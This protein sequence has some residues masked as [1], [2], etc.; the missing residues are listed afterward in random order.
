MARAFVAVLALAAVACG[1]GPRADPGELVSEE[2]IDIDGTP[3]TRIRYGSIDVNGGRTEVTG[4]V[5]I[6]AGDPPP[7]GWPV[8]A[9]AHSTTGG[10]DDCAPSSDPDVADVGRV[11][12]RLASEGF[13]A[14]A[15]DYEGIGG[16]GDHPYLHGRSEAQAVVDSVRAARALVPA[17]GLVWAVLGHSQGGHAAVFTAELAPELGPE[18]QLV[19]AVAV[20]PVSEPALLAVDSTFLAL[21]TVGYLSTD[22]GV[23]EEELLTDA[24]RDVIEQAREECVVAGVDE[25]LLTRSEP[26]LDAYLH[27]NAV[28][29]QATPVPV[30]IQ[31]GLDDELTPP[32]GARRALARL[33]QLGVAVEL[34]EY[35]GADHAT[36]VE[37]GFDDAVAWVRTRF[38][39]ELPVSSC[40]V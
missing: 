24:G 36:I 29:Q 19:G 11:L 21:A 38:A 32:G 26:A 3:A 12:T 39:G 40:A 4:L 8:I 31:Q 30:L 27:E 10:D 17:A 1:G 2:P 34:Q 35:R 15:T 5:V 37:A 23:D 22:P 6:P 14:V 20:A 9:W 33:C 7:E 25:P 16:P 18:L 28:G 13:V